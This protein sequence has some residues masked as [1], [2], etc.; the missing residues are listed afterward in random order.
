MAVK[1]LMFDTK[2]MERDLVLS[3]KFF[4]PRFYTHPLNSETVINIGAEERDSASVLNVFVDSRVTKEVLNHFK[5]LQIITTRSTGYNHIDLEECR[6]RD[7]TVINVPDYGMKAVSQYTIGLILAL[8]RRIVPATIAMKQLKTVDVSLMGKD[9][10]EMTLGIIGCGAIGQ[11]VAEIAN[12]FGMK[13]LGYDLMANANGMKHDFI[14]F[15]TTKELLQ[16]S[17]IIS[18]HVPYTGS[19]YHMIGKKE[20]EMM[21][22]DAYLINT[23]RGELVDT[24][25][26]YEILKSGKLAGVALDVVECEEISFNIGDLVKMLSKSTCNCL[27]RSL[28]VRKLAEMENVIITPHMAY[29]TSSAIKHITTTLLNNVKDHFKGHH[30]DNK[31]Y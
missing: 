29:Y 5:N 28:I 21:K 13:I 19:N 9:L 6:K 2:D 1:M 26:L 24:V 3:D 27:S 20:L 30:C 25:A 10:S 11:G 15:V 16:N 4:E 7:I 23:A 17:D 22:D 31:V 8:V 12:K 18:L 14:E